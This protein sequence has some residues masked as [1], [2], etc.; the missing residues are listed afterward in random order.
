MLVSLLFLSCWVQVTDLTPP[1]KDWENFE[2]PD[3]LKRRAPAMQ[4]HIYTLLNYESRRYQVKPTFV[5]LDR[6]EKKEGL[7][8]VLVANMSILHIAYRVH[9]ELTWFGSAYFQSGSGSTFHS[10]HGYVLDILPEDG[11]YTLSFVDGN[12]TMKTRF[13]QFDDHAVSVKEH[14]RE[15]FFYL[16]LLPTS[17]PPD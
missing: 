6:D 10:K 9:G 14:E 2:I 11:D 12:H 16:F 8:N 13:H 4:D 17:I 3:S 1:V 15:L 7:L 5:F